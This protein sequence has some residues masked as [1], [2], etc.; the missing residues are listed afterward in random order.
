MEKGLVRKKSSHTILEVQVSTGSLV[1]FDLPLFSK[2]DTKLHFG[3]QKKLIFLK[4]KID[5]YQ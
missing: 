2:H 3:H 4:G 5:F 1:V